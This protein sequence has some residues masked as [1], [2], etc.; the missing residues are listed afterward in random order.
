LL[1]L[2][3]FPVVV[4]LLVR[5]ARDAHAPAAALVLVD[6]HDA[7]FLALVDRPR[8]AAR[9]AGRVEAVLAQPR[10]VHQERVL[11]LAV[12]LL[13]D[14]LE[15]VVFLALLELAAEDLL[16]V[17]AALD[18]LH[19]LAGD[20]RARA[21]HRRRLRLGSVMQVLVV[22]R[23]RLVVI[24]QLGQVRVGED[25]RQQAELAALLR[26]DP[27][28]AVFHP[29]AV[30]AV[31]VLPVL[32]VADPGLGF[33]VVEPGVLHAGPVRPDVL[34]RDRARMAADALVQVQ[35]HPD[36]RADF[37]RTGSSS[38][39]RARYSPSS[40]A[41]GYSTSSSV[42]A[43][44]CRAVANSSRSALPARRASLRSTSSA[45]AIW[46]CSANI[47]GSSA[48]IRRVITSTSA[49]SARTAPSA[50]SLSS[51][52]GGRPNASSLTKCGCSSRA[53]SR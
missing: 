35:H 44:R 51:R 13:L 8:G 41:A 36:L 10:Q 47:A 31:L 30:P 49:M 38:R 27:A 16:P 17:R 26:L 5:A 28:V 15:V 11:E 23:E 40:T 43:C 14:F 33:D 48:L 39:T 53:T 37:H 46:R 1:G 32:R 21:R 22:E 12:H 50:T 42:S 2:A 20:E 45:A 6:Q 25:L 19:A 52:S 3:A 7:V 24:V 18:L 34:A 4:D 9:D 29:A